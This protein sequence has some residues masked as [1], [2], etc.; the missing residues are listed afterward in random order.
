MNRR[1][2]LHLL[3]AALA[4]LPGLPALA[5]GTATA[6]VTVTYDHPENFA[7]TIKERSLSPGS[8]SDAY[9]Q[10]LRTYM[11]QRA[12]R[13]LPPGDRLNIVVTNVDLAGSFEPWLGP[14]MQDVRI[15]KNIYPPR[16]D[17]RFR[18]LGPDGRVLRAGTRKLRDPGFLDSGIFSPTDGPLVYEKRLIDNW[19]RKG[20]DK[21]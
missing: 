15:I 6:N 21:L 11:E 4:A 16:I 2:A 1:I 5:A 7:E 12:A 3:L 18:L 17:L 14:Q 19:L 20:P 10:T 13:I 9:L 8:A